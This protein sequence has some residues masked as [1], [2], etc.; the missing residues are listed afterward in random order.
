MKILIV[1]PTYLPIVGG[2]E[3]TIYEISK[4]LI[5]RGIGVTILTRSV[6]DRTASDEPD[7]NV[8]RIPLPEIKIYTPWVP[9]TRT[10]RLLN[11]IREFC[12][13]GQ[14]D[15]IHQFH[16]FS[17]GA[18]CVLAKKYLKKPLITSLMGQDTYDPFNPIPKVFNPYQAWVVNNSDMVT[19][20]S[21]DLANH[22][23]E[24]GC[25]RDINIVPHGVDIYKFNPN[26]SGAEVRKKL[27][28]REDEIM[29]FSIQRLDQRKKLDYLIGAM[30]KVVK[31]NPNIKLV[32]GGKGP[33]REK[34]ELLAS[35]LNIGEN[36]VFVGFITEE[37]LPKYYSACDLFTFHTTYEAF[38]LVLAEAMARGKPIIS[39]KAGAIPEV[40]DDGKTG[41]LVPPL[42]SDALA[43]AILKL[44]NDKGTM[45][46]MANQGRK[47]VEQEYDWD[48]IVER[49]IGIYQELKC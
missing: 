45:T 46:K 7:V 40:I 27:Q 25:K 11:K 15:I 32:I 31:E 30:P 26:V 9:I 41:L 13:G 5:N 49:Y 16:V 17:F 29:L 22:A 12:H 28:I 10:V 34:L 21:Q 35:R 14:V 20:P 44:A 2:T 3:Q 33:E 24:Q 4:R 6:K 23:R 1:T 42:D 47:K 19:A 43:E 37:D 36:I 18:A 48:K 38:G 8:C 39:T